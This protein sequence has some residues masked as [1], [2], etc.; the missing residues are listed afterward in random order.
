MVRNGGLSTAARAYD[1]QNNIQHWEPTATSEAP[2]PVWK[3][4]EAG[5]VHSDSDFVC[6]RLELRRRIVDPLHY[7]LLYS[8]RVGILLISFD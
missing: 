4:V 1:E 3:F 6:F 8:R 5:G 2:D 7:S